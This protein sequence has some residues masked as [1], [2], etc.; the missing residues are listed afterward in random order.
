MDSPQNFPKGFLHR[1]RICC[2]CRDALFVFNGLKKCSKKE[3]E[4]LIMQRYKNS[5][6]K[7]EEIF[8]L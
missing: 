5:R 4:Q 3:Y 8:T 1:F 7:F 6:R 2:W